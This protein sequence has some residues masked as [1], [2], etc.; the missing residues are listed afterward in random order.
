MKL[1]EIQQT[2]HEVLAEYYGKA[3]INAFFFLLTEAYY[4][5]K[6]IDLAMHPE[7]ITENTD[8]IFEALEQLKHQ[9]PIQYILG[10]TEFF[11]LPF[12][13]SRD[14]LIPRPETEELVSWI[15][16]EVNK[17][18]PIRILDVG[19]GSGCIAVTLAKHLPNAAVFALDVSKDAL[20]IA[21]ENAKINS[22]D[23]TF[24]EA[25]I[26]RDSAIKF[27]PQILK[28]DI[29]VSN[30]PYVRH[31][32]KD[33]MNPNVLRNEPHLALFVEDNDPLLFY[34]A[35]TSF[36]IKHLK[37]NGQLFFEINEYLGKETVN[38]MKQRGFET[39]ALKKD[40][41]GK[42]RMVKAIYT[43]ERY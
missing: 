30:P 38:S 7:F 11:G 26:L 32:E 10:K 18:K 19:T 25:D 1:K 40:I 3:E 4:N 29:I 12:K 39:I 37:H 27:I 35:I 13:V 20:K 41:F 34:N 8:I 33:L 43:D 21:H 22:V 31:L 5:I 15:L 17:N 28:F 23:V 24:V 9:K 14:V 2:F 36:A 6:R 16:D 42:D